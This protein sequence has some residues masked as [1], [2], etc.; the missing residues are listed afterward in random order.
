M[1]PKTHQELLNTGVNSILRGPCKM[2]ESQ[3][4]DCQKYPCLLAS[5]LCF[6]THVGQS[7]LRT[8]G[9]KMI[10][11]ILSLYSL[12][13]SLL[14]LAYFLNSS[15]EKVISIL[16]EISLNILICSTVRTLS[17][18]L[19]DLRDLTKLTMP[20]RK[21]QNETCHPPWT[22]SL[23]PPHLSHGVATY[24]NSIF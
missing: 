21:Q 1:F 2:V 3:R 8:T 20:C 14:L 12:N 15:W 10:R 4:N 11:D 23:H 5:L 18:S 9:L 7:M 19:L 24:C 16:Q 17:T 13:I 6:S 22:Y